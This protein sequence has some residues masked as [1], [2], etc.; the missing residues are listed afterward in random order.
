MMRI[1]P[2]E[3]DG[4]GGA[5]L[6]AELHA[7]SGVYFADGMERIENWK[8]LMIEYWRLWNLPNRV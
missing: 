8:M 6:E 1:V 4:H 5:G 7:N 2:Y 3:A